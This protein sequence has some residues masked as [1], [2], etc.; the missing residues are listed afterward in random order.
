[1]TKDVILSISGV[2]FEVNDEPTE[3]ITGAGYYFKNGRHFVTYEETVPETG[4]TVKN[5]IKIDDT[6]VD[7]IKHGPQSVHMVFEKDKKNV[8]CYNTPF[9]SLFIGIHT[10]QM[11]HSEDD[12]NINTQIGYSLEIND[13]HVSDCRISLNIK[14][15]EDKSFH[16]Q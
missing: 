12:L 5:L 14:S 4:E 11:K 13:A 15:K 1:M 16:L 7:V 10:L 3:V 2:Q 8:T 6:R 9:G